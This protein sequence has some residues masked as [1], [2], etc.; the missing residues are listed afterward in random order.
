MNTR[1]IGIGYIESVAL[2]FAI[3]FT[4][5][6]LAEN[7]LPKQ[8]A[9]ITFEKAQKTLNPMTKFERH[10]SVVRISRK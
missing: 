8:L 1:T 3:H 7:T 6:G 5:Y 4:V 10:V 9:L 2:N